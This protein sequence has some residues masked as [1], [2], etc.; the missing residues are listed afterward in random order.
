MRV[1]SSSWHLT[2]SFEPSLFCILRLVGLALWP[3]CSL[4]LLPPYYYYY[5]YYYEY[6]VLPAVTCELYLTPAAAAA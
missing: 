5:Y 1:L 6:S 3:K 2:C 4:I